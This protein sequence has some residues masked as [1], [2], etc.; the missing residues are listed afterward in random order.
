VGCGLSACLPGFSFS[1]LDYV[2]LLN[3]EFAKVAQITHAA[4]L[5][6]LYRTDD[7]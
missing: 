5:T 2:V 4:F 1:F 7:N 3:Q 6:F